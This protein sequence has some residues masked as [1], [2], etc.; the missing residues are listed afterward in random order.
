[1]PRKPIIF[2]DKIYKT[3]SEFEA[4]V[5]KLLYKDIGICNDVKNSYP[6][7]YITLIEILKRHPDF[8]LKTQNMCKIKIH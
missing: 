1:M 2:L 4:F 8:I 6:S 3:Q 7:H 5:K